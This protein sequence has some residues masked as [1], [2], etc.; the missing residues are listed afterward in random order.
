MVNRLLSD[1]EMRIIANRRASEPI[2][3]ELSEL[4]V[5]IESLSELVNTN[6]DYQVAIPLLLDWL[7]RV[8]NLDVKETLVR[9]LTVKWAKPIAAI[10]L[11]EEFQNAPMSA[12]SFKWAIGNAL[13]VVADDSVFDEIVALVQ[14]KR[15]GRAREMLAVA[16]G[17]MKNP[18]AVEVLIGLL[19]D[20]EVAGHALS[21]LRKLAP[22]EAREAIEPFVDHPKTWIR[23]E[24]KR[25]LEKIDKKVARAERKRSGRK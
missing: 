19:D 12:E 17:N 8:S 9:A 6:V 7:P 13:S 15:H 5:R 24:A 3:A 25:A 4:G 14:D 18:K 11:I 1:R 20:E 16:L 23:N 2:L 10:P 22:P 21:A